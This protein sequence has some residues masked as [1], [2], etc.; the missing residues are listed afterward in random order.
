[1][2][3][4]HWALLGMVGYSAVTL[5]VK[6]AT[7]QGDF[8]SF[9]VL[10]IACIFVLISTMT[11]TFLRGDF[12]P[13]K[14]ANLLTPSALWSY[15]AGIALT[16]AV[17]ALFKALSMGPASTVVPIYGM[18]VVGGALLGFVVLGETITAQKVLGI[19]LA[20]CSIYLISQ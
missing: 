2:T 15:A 12:T 13:L 11:I 9:L 1:M 7:R 10:S 19:G 5:F 16:I 6:L 18:F 3:Y 4:V 8:S 14:V 20:A 17:T